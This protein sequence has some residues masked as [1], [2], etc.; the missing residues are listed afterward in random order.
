[1]AQLP[2][3]VK[4]GSKG[5]AVKGLQ[6][7]LNTRSSAVVSVDGVFGPATENAV[8]EFQSDAGL[9]ED[10]IVGPDTW[11]ALYVYLVQQGD[12]LS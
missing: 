12:T 11:G 2:P 1:M 3:T 9:A 4:S 7:A 5:E 8:K 10:G 6:N